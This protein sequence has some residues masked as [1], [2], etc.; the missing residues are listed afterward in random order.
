MKHGAGERC[1]SSAG[2]WGERD[3]FSGAHIDECRRVLASVQGALDLRVIE[4][5]GHW[6]PYEA[7]DQVTAALFDL[8]A[9]GSGP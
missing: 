3:A 1:S 9:C 4:G 6:V 2:I 8:L 5:A 7:A